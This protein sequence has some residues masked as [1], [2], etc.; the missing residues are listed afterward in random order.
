ML[1]I[2]PSFS[3]FFPLSLFFFF[4]ENAIVEFQKELDEIEIEYYRADSTENKKTVPKTI[5]PPIP[6]PPTPPTRQELRGMDNHSFDIY[7]AKSKDLIGHLDKD[8]FEVA[9]GRYFG[10]ICNN[11]SDPQFVGTNAPGINGLNVSAGNGLTT[12]QSGGGGPSGSG[13]FGSQS[14]NTASS[15]SKTNGATVKQGSAKKSS[16]T[17]SNGAGGTTNVKKKKKVGLVPNASSS[18]LRKIV[19]DGGALAESMKTCIV[20]AAV[21]ASRMGKHGQAFRATD[22]NIYPDISKAFAA[23]A[24]LK[25]CDRCKNNKQGVSL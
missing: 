20:R 25:P 16:S 10:L 21:H 14:A 19:E 24:G 15:P 13:Q 5:I 6:E 3:A 4:R 8:F 9:N 11:I 7:L 2:I 23:H 17:P 1:S 18:A 22:G 12:A